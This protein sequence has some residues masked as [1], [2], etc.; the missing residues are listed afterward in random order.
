MKRH[1]F[2]PLLVVLGCAL[3]GACADDDYTELNKGETELALT[4]DANDITLD[5][6]AHAENALTLTWTSG[7]NHGTGNRITYKLELAEVG[8]GFAN[9]YLVA[10]DMTQQY[11]W[12]STVEALNT[13]LRNNFGVKADNRYAVEARVTATVAG[14]DDV[15][16]ATT[17]FNVASYEPVTTTLY[18]TGTATL[19]GTDLSL[20]EEMTRTDNGQ[21]TYTGYMKAGTYKFI[22][23]LGQELPSY[24]RGDDGSLVLRTAADQPDNLF[25]ITED[26]DY[27]ITLNLLDGTITTVQSDGVKPPYDAIW[28]IDGMD[29]YSFKPMTQDVLDPFLFRY[30]AEFN[31]EG[32]FKFATASGSWENN[33]KATQP[34]APYTDSSVEF[35]KGFDPDNKWRLQSGELGKAYKICLDIRSGKERMLMAPFTPYENIWLVGDAAPGGWSLD[36]AVP[37]T[38]DASNPYVMTWT[39]TLNTGE[40]KF[41]CDRIS[42]W[43]GAW[44]MSA[45]NGA[46]PTGQEEKALFIDKHSDDLKAQYLTVDIMN[47]DNKWKIE[48]AGT[49]KITLNQLTETITIAKQ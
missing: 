37:M 26:H 32:D 22:T 6:A 42:D 31:N 43:N 16:T 29:G 38:K 30:G 5:E 18:V 4:A 1:I 34:D 33:Y 17:T 25:E 9:P 35:V 47:I 36:D 19:G 24:N 13:L 14:I 41:T 21:F 12:S 40:L 45:T 44:F 39:G 49:Y 23:T 11:T 3:L 2:R 20:A 46:A 27:T 15:Q 28:F 48:E 7:T 10:E 8:T